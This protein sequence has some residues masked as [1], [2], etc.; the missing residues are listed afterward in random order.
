MREREK[1]RGRERA[2]ER[3]GERVC[4]VR[5]CVDAWAV[6]W[7]SACAP[8]SAVDRMYGMVGGCERMVGG[9]ERIHIY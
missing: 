3:E 7:A 5:W 1:A 4:F 2:R 8:A 6:G 9:C